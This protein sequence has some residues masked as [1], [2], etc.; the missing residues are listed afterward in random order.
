MTWTTPKTWAVDE[1]LT[2]ADMNEQVR[3]NLDYLL[4][5]NNDSVE[6][7]NSGDYSITNVTTFQDVDGTNFKVTVTTHGGPILVTCNFSAT[8]GANAV[9]F[10]LA[11]DGVRVSAGTLGL[12]TLDIQAGDM[13]AVAIAY[14]IIGQSAG[15]YDITLQWRTA[16][17]NSAT[18]RANS[19]NN[20]AILQAV[21]I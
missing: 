6:Y 13:G 16:S 14:L 17:T 8:N 4:E 1:L 21:E 15:T 7:D 9:H 19:A 11:L 2:A 12:F 18:I 5:P 3:D 20:I 10:D